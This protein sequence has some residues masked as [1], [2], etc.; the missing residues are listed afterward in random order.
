MRAE[1]DIIPQNTE[2]HRTRLTVGVNIIDYPGE[3][4]TPTSDL[5]TIKLHVKSSIS[6]IK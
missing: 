6:D 2:T 4:N 5:T 3:V 1:C